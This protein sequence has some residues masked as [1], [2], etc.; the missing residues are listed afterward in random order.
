MIEPENERSI[1]RD[2]FETIIALEHLDSTISDSRFLKD[3]KN[4]LKIA[5][6]GVTERCTCAKR[7][8][9]GPCEV[10][11]ASDNEIY[12]LRNFFRVIRNAKKHNMDAVKI[13]EFV[14]NTKSR[15]K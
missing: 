5:L 3:T 4:Q 6:S 14:E 7:T 13:Q 8:W 1:L 2:F 11:Q 9:G 12:V 15:L 10:C